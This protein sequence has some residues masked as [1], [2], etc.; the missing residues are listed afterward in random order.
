MKLL[1]D[2][3]KDRAQIIDRENFRVDSFL[4]HQVDTKLLRTMAEEWY[5]L[6]KDSGV[7]KVLTIEASGIAPACFIADMLGCSM[8]FARKN[9]QTYSSG[10]YYHTK[11]VSFTNNREHEYSVR[12]EYL[13]E[14]DKVL[15]IDDILANGASLC[16]L[17]GICRQAEA[18]VIGAGVAIEKTF[19]SGG[20][21]V[22]D[23]GIR[24]EPLVRI[25]AVDP[26]NGFTFDSDTGTRSHNEEI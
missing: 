13:S 5:E 19:Q 17:V 11:V 22:R 15:I 16:A 12:K 14:S 23:M 4:N 20:S 2:I 1:E 24:V 3:I 9:R 25:S 6:F 18:E 8:V 21:M 26:V 10:D 7:T